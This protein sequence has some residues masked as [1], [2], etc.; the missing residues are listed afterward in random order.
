MENL[1]PR[2][3]SSK[4]KS[5]KQKKELPPNISSF[6]GAHLRKEE[7]ERKF[8]EKKENEKRGKLERTKALVKAACK[9]WEFKRGLNR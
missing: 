1:N 8:K 4:R 9:V 6:P 7:R 5:K 3:K 2:K